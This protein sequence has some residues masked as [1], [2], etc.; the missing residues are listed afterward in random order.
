MTKK[1]QSVERDRLIMSGL[2]QDLQKDKYLIKLDNVETMV[3]CTL[4]GKL[5]QNK[6]WILL[7]DSVD[8]EV[9]LNDPTKGRIVR[10]LKSQS[11]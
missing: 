4:S 9:C 7:G 2:V 8:I 5:R 6:I 10:R 3:Q 1:H 11:E